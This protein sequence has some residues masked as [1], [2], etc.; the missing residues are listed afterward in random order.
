VEGIRIRINP[1][2]R[3]QRMLARV[4]GAM[5]CDASMSCDSCNTARQEPSL[6]SVTKPSHVAAT[7]VTVSRGLGSGRRIKSSTSSLCG[8]A[9]DEE[10]AA[11]AVAVGWGALGKGGGRLRGGGCCKAAAA[12][13]VIG[14]CCA[15]S[16][17]GTGSRGGTAGGCELVAGWA[18]ATPGTCPSGIC[19]FC[20]CNESELLDQEK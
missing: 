6:A 14:S 9:D 5:P 18:A 15:G 11:R 2:S 4:W 16:R 10:E 7:A 17:V 3:K 1:K 13:A 19:A 20:C 12:A 8:V